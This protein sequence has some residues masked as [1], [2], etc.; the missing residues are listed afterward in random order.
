MEDDEAYYSVGGVGEGRDGRWYEELRDRRRKARVMVQGAA[1][2]WGGPKGLGRVE[3]AAGR[4]GE[5]PSRR[6]AG[7]GRGE[8]RGPPHTPHPSPPPGFPIWAG[9]ACQQRPH[10][11]ATG[12]GELT[13]AGRR[14]CKGRKG[15]GAPQGAAGRLTRGLRGRRPTGPARPGPAW[16]APPPPRRT[17][18]GPGG[19]RRGAGSARRPR[20]PRVGG[21]ALGYLCLFPDHIVGAEQVSQEQVELLLLRRGRRH[22]ARR[23]REKEGGET[24]AVRRAG[25][26]AGGAGAGPARGPA[27][28]SARD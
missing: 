19:R 25:G 14:G 20:A 24:G 27:P 9:A 26:P 28:A 18:R 1:R 12:G 7:K 21:G 4:A 2:V 10:V 5:A 15:L 23:E 11:C 13:G 6:K 3:T 22:C 17:N 8:T 16:P